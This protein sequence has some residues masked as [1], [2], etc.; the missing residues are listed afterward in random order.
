VAIRVRLYAQSILIDLAL[1]R[2]GGLHMKE[3]KVGETSFRSLSDE[4]KEQTTDIVSII[5]KVA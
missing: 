2:L 3:A 4:V 5:K 1:G